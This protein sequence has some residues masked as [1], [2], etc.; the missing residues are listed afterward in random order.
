MWYTSS[1]STVTTELEDLSIGK[2]AEQE[3][4]LDI[5]RQPGL[6]LSENPSVGRA[7]ALLLT[8]GNYLETNGPL[9]KAFPNA[10]DQP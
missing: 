9:L 5:F 2:F 8:M 4:K 1:V 10:Q 3:P 7:A 6:K